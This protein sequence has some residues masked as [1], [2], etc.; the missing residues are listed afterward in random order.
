MAAV[1]LRVLSWHVFKV[2]DEA[3][4]ELLQVEGKTTVNAQVVGTA[5]WAA[6]CEYR[7]RLW[8]T[9]KDA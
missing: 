7:S 8:L 9:W 5:R 2:A 1:A 4:Q 3:A 6:L